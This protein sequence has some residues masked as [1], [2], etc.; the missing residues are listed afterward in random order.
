MRAPTVNTANIF[1]VRD[2]KIAKLCLQS[3]NRVAW[4]DMSSPAANNVRSLRRSACGSDA[5]RQVSL[6]VVES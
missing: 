1:L 5:A 3:R 2:S 4:R 6:E